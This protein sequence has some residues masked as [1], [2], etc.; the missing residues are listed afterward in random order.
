MITL[1]FKRIVS[2]LSLSPSAASQLTFY[3][4]RL[5]HEEGARKLSAIGAI[6]VFMLQFAVILAPPT[7][8]NAASS[9]DIILG[10]IVSKND[11]LNRYDSSAE[12]KALYDRF[13]ISR[14]DITHTS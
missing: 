11:L 5:V 7:P 10:G 3:S 12:L 1:M 4:R 9:N 13:D 6:L 14:A 8:S 2:Q